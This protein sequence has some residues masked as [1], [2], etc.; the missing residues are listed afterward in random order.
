MFGYLFSKTDFCSSSSHY[1]SQGLKAYQRDS[2]RRI[3]LDRLV[4]YFLCL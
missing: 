4:F 3:G 2:R 1:L